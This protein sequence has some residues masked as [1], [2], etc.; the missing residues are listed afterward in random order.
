[1]V[2]LSLC[3]VPGLI[4]V[5]WR[6]KTSSA[7]ARDRARAEASLV[8]AG[9]EL[10][11]SQAQAAVEIISALAK[12][13]GP[14]ALPFQKLAAEVLATRPDLASL[15]LQPA[16]IVSDTFPR[17]TNERALRFNVFKDPARRSAVSLAIQKRTVTVA[18]PVRLAG[19]EIGINVMAPVFQTGRDGREAF[20]GFITAAIRLPE[21][22]GRAGLNELASKGYHYSFFAPGSAQ[23][24]PIILA[25]FGK[26]SFNRAVLQPVRLQNA[27][28]RLSLHPRIGW[29]DKGE[30]LLEV[31]VVLGGSGL[32]GLA[33]ITLRTKRR[34]ENNL[35]QSNQ[36]LVRETTAREQ[37]QG[38][39]REAEDRL[40]SVKQELHQ[41]QSALQKSDEANRDLQTRVEA[42]TR[43]A[44]EKEEAAHAS[45]QAVEARRVELE[46]QLKEALA[47]A[48][49]LSR[50]HHAEMQRT[51]AAEATVEQLQAAIRDL[52]ARLEAAR[53]ALQEREEAAADSLKEAQS[54]TRELQEQLEQA[55]TAVKAAVQSRQAEMEKAGATEAVIRRLEAANLDLQAR[56]EAATSAL[57]EQEQTQQVNR[58]K[59][60]TEMTAVHQRADTAEPAPKEPPHPSEEPEE[61]KLRPALE[62]PRS[63]K[64]SQ[65]HP[66]TTDRPN[67]LWP[68]SGRADSPA[69]T[70]PI[71][72]A[73]ESAVPDDLEPAHVQVAR[74]APEDP[75]TD[76]PEVLEQ[77]PMAEPAA[78]HAPQ[79]DS[80]PAETVEKPR[81]HRPAP[82]RV[83]A[84]PAHPEFRKMVHQILPLLVDQ[85]P[86]A[87]ECL[88]DN[89]TVFRSG[90]A[91]E[92]YAEFEQ[93]VKAGQ[94]GPAME[95]LK[96]AA[97]K[98]GISI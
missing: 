45:W 77:S 32:L 11:V 4:S 18:A 10:Q 50:A 73:P 96:R 6:A 66:V 40:A 3:L 92:H 76:E 65:R 43:G 97:R 52:Q 82:P 42:V 57:K 83:P 79:P 81:E 38:A 44:Q 20:W 23:Q 78:S 86:G 49:E 74:L 19:G 39:L 64:L 13:G 67:D 63:R 48:G 36:K 12:Q 89:R 60:S 69:A 31:M 61:K 84:T 54:Q 94:F 8:A 51:R 70:P 55:V 28:L 41:A 22:L 25:E 35:A 9:L 34:L 7:T 26:P 88:R 80:T 68:S 98:H 93:L 24:R 59:T 71:D 87:K 46:N 21:A 16:G 58:D 37:A 5:A 33:V 17:R 15:E 72:E 91:P 1:V 53:S 14:A 2:I 47:H 85:D 27:E 56:L 75:S 95:Q 29:I 62:E 30:V 90:F